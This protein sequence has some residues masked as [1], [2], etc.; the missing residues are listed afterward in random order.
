MAIVDSN[1]LRE[2]DLVDEADLDSLIRE[3]ILQVRKAGSYYS[4]VDEIYGILFANSWEI[5]EICGAGYW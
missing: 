5:T 3:A 4:V 1:T 2:E